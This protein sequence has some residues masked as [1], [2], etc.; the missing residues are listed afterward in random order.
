[1]ISEVIVA[2]GHPRITAK[3]RTTFM[4]TKDQGV[5]PKGDCIIG[6]GADK[7]VSDLSPGLKRAIRT[8]RELIITLKVGG[9]IEKIHARG[10]PSLT[11]DHSTDMVVRKSKF[12]CGRTLAIGADKAAADMS[13][14]F[15][16]ALK[17]PMT[18]LELRIEISDQRN[19]S[20]SI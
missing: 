6:V 14:K 9:L 18:K 1:M 17:N 10:H 3:H 20:G 12:I 2:R 11:L 13:R 15:V 4:V 8:D 7:A 5:G 16:S 19:S